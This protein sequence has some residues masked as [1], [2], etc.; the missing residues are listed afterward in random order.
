MITIVTGLPC[1]GK[2]TMLQMLAAGGMP[3]LQN[4]IAQPSMATL[5]N[6]RRSQNSASHR[7][8]DTNWLTSAE[9]KACEIPSASLPD[10]P[11]SHEYRIICMLRDLDHSMAA[12]TDT[13]AH[14]NDPDAMPPE[15]VRFQLERHLRRMRRLL[16]GPRHLATC[17]CNYEEMLHQPLLVVRQVVSFLGLRLDS[18]AMVSL[19]MNAALQKQFPSTDRQQR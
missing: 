9:G 19:A 11:A 2:S 10:L 1:S 4:D 14:P 5:S 18:K 8:H 3:I 15:I 12:L 13:T 17:Y 7:M 16:D 6:M